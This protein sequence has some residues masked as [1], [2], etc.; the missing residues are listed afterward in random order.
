MTTIESGSQFLFAYFFLTMAVVYY[1]MCQT[2]QLDHLWTDKNL[3]HLAWMWLLQTSCITSDRLLLQIA[4]AVFS[5]KSICEMLNL[6]SQACL[7][8]YLRFTSTVH[9]AVSIVQKHCQLYFLLKCILQLKLQGWQ[10]TWLNL[11]H[12][13]DLCYI[14]SWKAADPRKL[15]FQF[16][17]LTILQHPP[18]NYSHASLVFCLWKM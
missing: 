10:I 3:R 11:L 5:Y 15:L 6:F 12:F 16:F 17:L 18:R 13:I 2:L 7:R 8:W 4:S 9:F 14:S 1:K